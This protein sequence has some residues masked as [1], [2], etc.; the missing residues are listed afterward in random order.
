MAVKAE[1]LE[2]FEQWEERTPLLQELIKIRDVHIEAIIFWLKF[3]YH[4]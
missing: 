1:A 4:H 2:R 3:F